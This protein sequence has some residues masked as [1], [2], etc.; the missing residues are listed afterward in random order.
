VGGLSIRTGALGRL[1]FAPFPLGLTGLVGI[2]VVNPAVFSAIEASVVPIVFSG[3]WIVLG[4]ALL[5]SGRRGE[6]VTPSVA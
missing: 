6:P 3:T 5:I 4:L 2:A 1:S